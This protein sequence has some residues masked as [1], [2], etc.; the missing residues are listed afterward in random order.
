MIAAR[1]RNAAPFLAAGFA[2]GSVAL[3][4]YKAR[5]STGKEMNNLW[6]WYIYILQG[7]F[8]LTRPHF[9]VLSIIGKWAKQIKNRKIK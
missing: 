2:A 8:L 3:L 5:Y 1:L 4:G 6:L 7:S 9:A